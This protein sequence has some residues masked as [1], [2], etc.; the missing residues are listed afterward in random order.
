MIAAKPADQRTKQENEFL[1]GIQ[2]MYK[3]RKGMQVRNNAAAASTAMMLDE[4]KPPAA[5][6]ALAQKRARAKMMREH[7]NKGK[8]ILKNKEIMETEKRR[9]AARQHRLML[10]RRQEEQ[11]ELVTKSD[12]PDNN[13]QSIV[14]ASSPSSSFAPTTTPP[15]KPPRMAAPAKRVQR[16]T[17]N[18]GSAEDARSEWLNSSTPV[19]T[20]TRKEK[21]GEGEGEEEEEENVTDVQVVESKVPATKEQIEEAEKQL[22]GAMSRRLGDNMMSA[23]ATKDLQN[24][25]VVAMQCGGG[26]DPDLVSRAKK[27]LMAVRKNKEVNNKNKNKTT[28]T[29]KEVNAS[30]YSGY[31]A[32]A[33]SNDI[34]QEWESKHAHLIVEAEKR[35]K[36]LREHHEEERER[37]RLE[38]DDGQ[39]EFFS[40]MMQEGGGG[41]GGGNGG[42]V[43][44]KTTTTMV[45]AVPPPTGLTPAGKPPAARQSIDPVVSS[46]LSL[47]SPMK[48]SIVTDILNDVREEERNNNDDMTEAEAEEYMFGAAGIPQFVPASREREEEEEEELSSSGS[49]LTNALEDA[50]TFSGPPSTPPLTNMPSPES[51]RR[52]SNRGS[53]DA[54]NWRTVPKFLKQNQEEEEERSPYRSTLELATSSRYTSPKHTEKSAEREEG[55]KATMAALKDLEERKENGDDEMA[56][57]GGGWG[58]LEEE[59]LPAFMLLEECW[60]SVQL[61]R[62]TIDQIH[63]S[64]DEEG[65][66]K[67]KKKKKSPLD[68]YK[69]KRRSPNSNFARATSEGE[70]RLEYSPWHNRTAGGYNGMKEDAK[71]MAIK[72][73]FDMKVRS[74]KNE[75]PMEER[76][77]AERG[78]FADYMTHLF[79]SNKLDEMPGTDLIR[80]IRR[81]VALTIERIDDHFGYMPKEDKKK[82]AR[83][84]LYGEDDDDG[85]EMRTSAESQAP[86][87]NKENQKERDSALAAPQPA[88]DGLPWSCKVCSKKNGGDTSKCIVCGRLQTSGPIKVS[89]FMTQKIKSENDS[90]TKTMTRSQRMGAAASRATTLPAGSARN[91]IKQ[92]K[93]KQKKPPT[94]GGRYNTNSSQIGNVQRRAVGSHAPID[95]INGML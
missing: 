22:R 39:Q 6:L 85:S 77:A 71:A 45:V 66:R 43:G 70:E 69:P 10:E 2:E 17:G 4:P 73:E 20:P 11:V 67:V 8:Q 1:L 47:S 64:P 9:E 63:K 87:T 28:A 30:K 24:R 19:Q 38:T 31:H 13:G 72:E 57:G 86:A 90:T 94:F 61:A 59:Q 81:E 15:P 46:S 95:T 52:E 58:G 84:L 79:L 60:N 12:D 14:K 88:L 5:L 51:R 35:S 26:V 75:K 29:R 41:G 18:G 56:D 55:V 93:K 91:A 16:G 76:D 82:A 83:E 21:K 40:Q 65:K 33:V 74:W 25:L 36:M 54:E 34:A 62:T 80:S 44:D 49:A 23:L 53:N 48:K 78:K 7:K 37:E 32:A 3:H 50:L 27:L 42:I 92:R 89:K 68:K